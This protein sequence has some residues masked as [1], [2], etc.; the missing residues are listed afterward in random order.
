MLRYFANGAIR[1]KE[2]MRCNTRTNW[3]FYA[4][5][6]GRCGLAFNDREKPTFHEKTLWVFPPECSHRWLDDGRTKYHRLA[7][8]FG[9][10]PHPLDLIVREK[11]YLARSLS[12][13]DIARL[14][15]LATELEPHFLQPNVLSHF[16]FQGRLM[17]LALL[18]LAGN[19]AKQ[20]PALPDLANFRVENALQWYGEHLDR[21]PSV[22]EVATALHVSVSHLRRLFWQARGSSPKAAFQKLR[23][24]RVQDLMSTTAHTLDEIA[25]LCGYHSASHLCHDYREAH[26]FTPTYWRKKLIDRFN[27]PPPSGMIALRQFS[28]RPHER[29]MRA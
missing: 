11:G 6:K 15:A 16:V 19:D 25:Q 18:A 10:V 9:S 17:D 22:K 8:H 7:F 27:N 20:A 29:R 3:E 21:H 23:R 4:V 1:W 13:D 14:Q 24:E 2:P 12:D 5:V 28:A 26:R